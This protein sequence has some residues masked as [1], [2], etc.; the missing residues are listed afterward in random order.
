MEKRDKVPV[1]TDTSPRLHRRDDN[2]DVTAWKVSGAMPPVCRPAVSVSALKGALAKT[3]QEGCQ[4]IFPAIVSTPGPAGFS[5]TQ[6]N[7]FSKRKGS[8]SGQLGVGEDKPLNSTS[9]P[10]PKPPPIW[11]KP[12]VAKQNMVELHSEK[13]TCDTHQ[14][15]GS[16]SPKRKPLPV[17][18]V[19][20]PKPR[21]PFRVDLYQYSSH[22]SLGQDVP[23]LEDFPPPPPEEFPLPLVEDLPPPAEFPPPP[24]EAPPPP[25]DLSFPAPPFALLASSQELE[26]C[27]DDVITNKEQ[28]SDVLKDEFDD[29]YED[30]EERWPEADGH[31]EKTN[32]KNTKESKEQNKKME[33]EMKKGTECEKKEKKAEREKG[34]KEAEREKKEKKEQEKREKEARKRFKL[35]GPIKVLH[36]S[37]VKL[38]CRGGKW[39]LALE[40]AEMVEIIRTTGNPDG[41]WLARNHRGQFG[42]VSVDNIQQDSD[43]YDDVGGGCVYDNA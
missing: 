26:D 38:N 18:G 10:F 25:A 41:L 1:A 35:K 4:E 24:F 32:K 12:S 11:K 7:I 15:T 13:N 16:T 19:R 42:Y 20:P 31:H 23:A 39:S 40:Q 3:G 5:S 2:D 21:R 30:I 33:K 29:T 34:K 27:Y 17:V 37:S 14:L 36:V 9:M 22:G 6:G 8:N 43:T 28:S